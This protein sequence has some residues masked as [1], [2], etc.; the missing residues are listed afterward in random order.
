MAIQIQSAVPASGNGPLPENF[1]F[2]AAMA[3]AG[4]DF[5]GEIIPDGQ[6]HRVKV[7]GD[8]GPNSWYVLHPDGI[9]AGS[10]GCWKRGLS[11]NWCAKTNDT[12]TEAERADR[13]RKW[14]EQRAA[15]IADQRR[16]NDAAR[17]SAQTIL[18]KALPADD[19]HPYLQRKGVH[20]YPGVKVGAWPQRR[21]EGCLLI[22]ARAMDGRLATVQAIFPDRPA[23]GRD[24]DFLKGGAK[25]GAFFAIGDLAS[26][27]TILIAEGYATAATL[28]EATGYPA[29][30]AFDAGNLAPVTTAIRS[31]YLK[32]PLVICADND[33]ATPGNPG[34]SKARR[35]VDGYNTVAVRLAVPKFTEDER[36]SDFND[37]ATLHGL[38]AVRSTVE[39]AIRGE[40]LSTDAPP[41]PADDAQPTPRPTVSSWRADLI[42]NSE[43]VVSRVLP[44]AVRIAEN[45]YPGL[46]RYNEFSRRIEA[47]T[48][49]PW[50]KE[51]GSWSDHDTRELVCHVVSDHNLPSFSSDLMNEGVQTA[52]R[53]HP[54]NPAQ[55]R[56]RALAGQWDG[57]T[58][59][60][61]WLTRYLNAEATA[62]NQEYLAEIGAAWLK[63]VCARVLMPGCKRD[64]VLTLVGPQ[65]FLKSSAAQAI[66][67][68]ILPDSF[69]DSL[70]NLGSDEAAIGVQGII[71]AEFSEL[72]AMGRS[73]LEAVKA[74][75]TR[76]S[77]RYREKYERMP[78]DHPRTCSFIA[79]TNDDAGFLRDPS[80]NRRWWPVKVTRK[81]DL[82]ALRTVIPMLL[83]EAASRVLGGE[84]WHVTNELANRQAEQARE[85]HKDSDVWEAAVLN[86]AAHLPDKERTISEILLRINVELPRQDR[87]AQN[88]VSNILRA[89]GYQRKRGRDGRGTLVYLWAVPITPVVP[90]TPEGEQEGNSQLASQQAGCSP[91]PI[92]SPNKNKMDVG[93]V[94]CGTSAQPTGESNAPKEIQPKRNF[95]GERGEHGEHREH[96]PSLPHGASAD[97]LELWKILSLY[98]GAETAARLARKL[99]WGEGRAVTAAQ[100]LSNVGR[101][102]ISGDCI[103][104]IHPPT[105]DAGQRGYAP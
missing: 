40:R 9:A 31:T 12:L 73:E 96:L 78:T 30:V 27:A 7:D 25:T 58:R 104:P 29:V 85:A 13:D 65:G 57:M 24:K 48:E 46:I 60:D 52:A 23:D 84:Q 81:I 51:P 99:G 11:E 16:Q 105:P 37:L 91:V 26:A 76:R 43:D 8:R 80:G 83:G 63:G 89:N 66:A 32:T 33:R 102:R 15:R 82:D 93:S 6:L 62:E 5:P 56:L 39:A 19:E 20:A 103:A 71:I 41:P 45:A 42:R 87:V 88:R 70:G 100:E 2:R 54:F 3:A 4:L 74:F 53:R 36:G 34:L 44:N 86:A 75:I 35:I 22:P 10:F 79:T 28:H 90:I 98:R 68:G 77:D 61:G 18:D 97:A 69:T 94:E 67:E 38:T 92:C 47:R 101:A 14:E 59:L 55:D 49:A 95:I 17:A 1:Q 50:R 64:D 72:A 21:L